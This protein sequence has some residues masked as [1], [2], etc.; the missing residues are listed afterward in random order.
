MC[1]PAALRLAYTQN[2]SAPCGQ[3]VDWDA[4]LAWRTWDPGGT[5]LQPQHHMA[6]FVETL[7][8]H[9]VQAHYT[10][11]SIAARYASHGGD[12]FFDAF[13]MCMCPI[14]KAHDTGACEPAIFRAINKT[15]LT[16]E[17]YAR[18]EE[19]KIPF[20]LYTQGKDIYAWMT[21]MQQDFFPEGV[22]PR[23]SNPHTKL[24]E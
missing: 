4:G 9:D 18:T 23:L 20:E 13:N 15:S 12:G 8:P 19:R 14:L 22:S 3:V 11:A 21:S 2:I 5:V 10:A 24:A 1:S 16:A 6:A 7:D 17:D